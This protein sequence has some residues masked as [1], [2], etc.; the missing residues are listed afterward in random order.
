[1]NDSKVILQTSNYETKSGLYVYSNT[2]RSMQSLGV[3]VDNWLRSQLAAIEKFVT[4]NVK[5][6]AN[7]LKTNGQYYYK[8]L[9]LIDLM[10]LNISK[11]CKYFEYSYGDGGYISVDNLRKF[12]GGTYNMNIEVSHVYIGPHKGGQHYSLSLHIVQIVYKQE[13]DIDLALDSALLDAAL[14]STSEKKRKRSTKKAKAELENKKEVKNCPIPSRAE[15]LF[16]R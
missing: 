8:P 2:N 9:K 1:M 14:E 6:P 3:P 4:S 12:T 7:V 16:P 15:V 11:W 13:N 10:F 5:I